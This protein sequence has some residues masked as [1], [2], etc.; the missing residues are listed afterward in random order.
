MPDQE[1]I[2]FAPPLP[3]LTFPA[4]IEQAVRDVITAATDVC[5]TKFATLAFLDGKHQYNIYSHGFELNRIPIQDS[6]IYRLKQGSDLVI[7]EDLALTQ[8]FC[9]LSLGNVCP[10]IQFYAGIPLQNKRKEVLGYLCIYH[11]KPTKITDV[12]RLLLRTLASQ[13]VLL[14][15]DKDAIPSVDG[16]YNHWDDHLIRR[17]SLF[18]RTKMVTLLLG[19]NFSVL[20]CHPYL[21]KLIS[22]NLHREIQIG[23]DIRDYLG[24][25]TMPE[26][27]NNY[28]RALAGQSISVQTKSGICW[29]GV[30]SY[31]HFSPAYNVEGDLVGVSY[32][33]MPIFPENMEENISEQSD[34]Q[35]QWLNDLQSHRF[36]G[37]LSSILGITQIWKELGSTPRN[38]EID[39]I[40]QAANKLDR[41]IQSVL[42]NLAKND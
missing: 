12:Q 27:I 25:S 18:N 15:E 23:D 4:S 2:N 28:N 40:I 19:K 8:Q 11:D 37:P 13:I 16:K 14:I 26:F 41:E 36:R 42:F 5:S 32:H 21:S 17:E 7:V 31:C 34:Q 22:E 39:M 1:S 33:A 10:Q 24:D 29:G 30:N 6:I 38:E 35:L 3:M 20:K 9:N